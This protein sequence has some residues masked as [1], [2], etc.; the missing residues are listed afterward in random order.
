MM[1]LLLTISVVFLVSSCADMQPSHGP[2]PVSNSAS[3]SGGGRGGTGEVN[4]GGRSVAEIQEMFDHEKAIFIAIYQHA[5]LENTS[6]SD[7]TIS[8]RLTIAPDGT[9][10]ECTIVSSTFGDPDLERT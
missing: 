6:L 3:P 8:I 5:A 9:V 2:R 4:A 7:G 10:T 1:R